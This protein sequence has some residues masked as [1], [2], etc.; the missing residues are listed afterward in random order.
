MSADPTQPIAPT[1][2]EA[3][4]AAKAETPAARARD[5]ADQLGVSEGAL[6][7]ARTGEGVR[8]LAPSGKD[9]AQFVEALPALGKVMTLTRNEAAV[10]ETKGAIT[11]TAA[12]GA[13]GQVTGPIDLRLFYSHW[14][15]GYAVSEETR[16][17][18]RHSFQIFDETGQAVIKIYTLADGDLAAFEHV[19]GRFED[20]VE[21]I[22]TFS[23]PL[24]AAAERPDSDI[25]VAAL[26]QGWRNLEHTHAFH[27]L[28][29]ETGAGRL[30]ALRLAGD[31]LACEVAPNS[32]KALLE[33]AALKGIPIMCFVGNPGCIQIFSGAVDRIALMGPWLNVL[34]PDFNLHLR[35]DRVA[36]TWRVTKPT[37]LRGDIN[38][39]ELYDSAGTVLCQFF[40]AR[41]P[42]EDERADWRELALAAG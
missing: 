34:D 42:G 13:M 31:E 27:R 21:R 35:T 18:L 28:L 39:I 6:V 3:W 19:A 23:Q 15:V 1:L 38:S 36:S 7:E 20:R 40:G 12:H 41:P 30:Q 5:I 14:H 2:L 4:K 29:R 16:S 24:A 8:R 33:G 37:S 9:F 17:G 11:E 32:T 26:R 22:A 10:H 25:D